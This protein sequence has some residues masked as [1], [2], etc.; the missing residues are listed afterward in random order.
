MFQLLLLDDDWPNVEKNRPLV[1]IQA[2]SD[3]KLRAGNANE[4]Q[5]MKGIESKGSNIRQQKPKYLPSHAAKKEVNRTN[6]FHEI[7]HKFRNLDMRKP[8][9]QVDKVWTKAFKEETT[10]N[11][12][13]K[14][15]GRGAGDEAGALLET[16]FTRQHSAPKQAPRIKRQPSKCSTGSGLNSNSGDAYKRNMEA[17][18][19]FEKVWA[20]K[21]D[22]NNN[23]NNNN[24][25]N[26]E[27]LESRETKL[28]RDEKRQFQANRSHVKNVNDKKMF[29]PSSHKQVKSAK[30]PL[31]SGPP[32]NLSSAL[33]PKRVDSPEL[34]RRS[35]SKVAMLRREK[36]SFMEGRHLSMDNR[37]E[38]QPPFIH[39]H[40]H[41]NDPR[42]RS[43]HELND[44]DFNF[45]MNMALPHPHH[46][47]HNF[48]H[49]GKKVKE[50]KKK[51]STSMS[52]LPSF[53]IAHPPHFVAA[54]PAAFPHH[55]GGPP[56]PGPFG[57]TPPG[58]PMSSIPPFHHGHQMPPSRVMMPF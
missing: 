22:L 23:N 35:N 52:I 46:G 5:A 54:T 49:S 45:R 2:Y 58:P 40:N 51:S 25:N 30:V 33:R 27:K 38:Q 29:V 53:G 8:D 14:G 26:D 57:F 31:K 50:P 6:S 41:H 11:K 24:N 16:Y 4:S 55:H 1:T 43:Y 48:Q 32:P 44:H 10:N 42:R 3:R 15:G 36:T 17:V 12:N 9:E 7:Q 20:W 21:E 34:V 13:N 47:R 28:K 18:G 56:P 37:I 19:E 39:Y